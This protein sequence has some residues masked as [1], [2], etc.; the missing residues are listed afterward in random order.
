[1]NFIKF[2]ALPFLLSSC[3]SAPEYKGSKSDHFDGEVFYN[4]KP[5]HKTGWDIFKFVVTLPFKK[6]S[7]PEWIHESPKML[8]KAN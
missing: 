8:T 1:M 3:I 2:F 7:W 4:R 6:Q 5:M